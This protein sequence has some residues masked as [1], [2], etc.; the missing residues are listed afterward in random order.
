MGVIV[1]DCVYMICRCVHSFHIS[2]V[3]D[4]FVLC[5]RFFFFVFVFFFCVFVFRWPA[6][7]HMFVF[8]VCVGLFMHVCVFMCVYVCLSV[9]LCVCRIVCTFNVLLCV[10]AVS[11]VVC[12]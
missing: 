3:C 5:V 8:L 11:V 1:F 6:V 9:C 4:L 7:W 10:R 12:V 2:G